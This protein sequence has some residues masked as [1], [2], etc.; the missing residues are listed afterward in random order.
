MEYIIIQH[1][2]KDVLLLAITWMHLEDTM[3]SEISQTHKN[4][5]CYHLHVELQKV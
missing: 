3:P 4:T 5:V 1:K 2:K